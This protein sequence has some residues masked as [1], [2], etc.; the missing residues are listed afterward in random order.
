MDYADALSFYLVGFHLVLNMTIPNNVS[1][2]SNY[3]SQ[4]FFNIVHSCPLALCLFDRIC[5]LR[6]AILTFSS[7]IFLTFLF[8]LFYRG[9]YM[10][11]PS[12]LSSVQTRS[13][14]LK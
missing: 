10:F 5:I 4:Y 6:I 11:P 14:K 13:C 2:F 12:T 8:I 1:F 9:V 3:L 7:V